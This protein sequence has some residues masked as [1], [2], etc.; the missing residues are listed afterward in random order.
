MPAAKKARWKVPLDVIAS[1]LMLPDSVE[2][3]AVGQDSNYAQARMCSLLL[4]GDGLPK[5]CRTAGE[6]TEVHGRYVDQHGQVRL[7]LQTAEEDG[8]A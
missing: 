1:A 5:S 2:I 6:P 8:D 4:V 7:F 3:M